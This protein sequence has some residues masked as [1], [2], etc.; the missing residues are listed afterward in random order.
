VPFEVRPRR[1]GDI[2]ACYAAAAEAR[3][4]LGWRAEK[5]LE[6]MCEDYWSWQRMNPN[7]YSADRN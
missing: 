1:P 7:G 3:A 4:I 2:A 6:Q 5:N